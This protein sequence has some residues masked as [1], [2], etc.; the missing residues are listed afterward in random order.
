MTE[1]GTVRRDGDVGAV[2]FEREYG[3]PPE[4]L[5]EAWTAPGRIKRWL[6]ADVSGGPIAAGGSF[7]LEWGPEEESK[8]WV[9]VLAHEPPRLLEWSWTV[10]GEKPSTLR[11]E[12]TPVPGG[13]RL[14]L[15]HSG[16]SFAQFAGISSGWHDFLDVLGSGVP[17][18]EDRWRELLPEYK[19][20]VAAL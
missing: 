10:T 18:D 12:L 1:F 13:T 9:E 20:R 3:S 4:D 6:G 15:D 19:S 16:L 11:V 7:V 14:V 8:T 17:S 5:W 2:R